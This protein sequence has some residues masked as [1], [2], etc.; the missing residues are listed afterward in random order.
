VAGKNFP[1]TLVIKATDEATGKLAKINAKIT[2]ALAPSRKLGKTFEALSSNLGLPKLFDAFK[3]VGTAI[4]NVGSEA[5]AFGAKLV[6]MGAVAGFA[7]YGITKGAIE[8]GDK[9]SEMAQRTGLA[10]DTYASLGFAMAQSDVDAEQFNASMDKFNKNLGEAKAGGGPLLEFLKKT[11]PGLAKQ[12]KGAKSTEEGISLMTDAL[13]RIEDPQRRAALAAAAFGKGGL[14]MGQALGQGSAAIQKLQK[15]YL[16][17]HGSSNK[18]ASGGSDL[19]NAMRRIEVAF[20]GLRDAAAGELFPA[21]T[22]LS[23]GVAKFVASN[24]EGLRAWAEKTGAAIMAWVQG[25]GIDRV[26]EGLREF[27]DTVASV[28]DAVGGISGVLK[29]AIGLMGLPLIGAVLSVIPALFS[30]VLAIVQVNLALSA[31]GLT[32]GAVLAPILAILAPIAAV[33]AAVAGLALAGYQLWKHWG[34]LTFIF[35]DFWNGLVFDAL[36]AWDKIKPIVDA[37]AGAFSGSIMGKII[38]KV[39][40]IGDSGAKTLGGTMFNLNPAAPTGADAARPGGAAAAPPQEV[41]VSFANAPKGTRVTGSEN[42]STEVNYS[43]G[44]SMAGAM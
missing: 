34:D 25:G 5:F 28:V 21:L 19:D 1:I 24:R 16:E 4:S 31:A 32:F 44:P 17:L 30:L 33:T 29:I 20:L 36:Q 39:S 12:I 2:S 6:G 27:K 35:K 7:L 11:G 10:V 15:E 23:E 3:G 37:I 43:V 13:S 14:Q 41:L 9:L 42:V 22:K 38:G 8:A 40:S 26:I 18:L